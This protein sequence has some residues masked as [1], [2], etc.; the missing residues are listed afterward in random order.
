LGLVREGFFSNFLVCRSPF[1]ITKS[2][3]DQGVSLPASFRNSVDFPFSFFRSLQ[4][5][6][7][8]EASLFFSETLFVFFFS[9][10]GRGL[11]SSMRE[12]FRTLRNAF[13]F[14]PFRKI[15]FLAFPSGEAAPPPFVSKLMFSRNPLS[16]VFPDRC[17]WLPPAGRHCCRRTCTK[18]PPGF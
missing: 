8:I 1:R 17:I 12:N 9:N 14:F 16:S 2:S 7:R 4:F 11:F 15:W 10:A 6:V 3:C 13:F 18:R 5:Q